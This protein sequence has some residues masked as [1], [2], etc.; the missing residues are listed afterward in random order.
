MKCDKYIGMDVH[1]ATTVVAVLDGEG[2]VILE[3]IVA[4]EA[5]AII[6]FLQSISG[7]VH[8]T[9]EESTQAEWLYEVV[10]SFVTE[11]I[12]C[13]PR[14]NQLL[15]EGSKGDKVDAHKLADL[16]RTG[17][18]RSVYHGHQTLKKLKQLVRGYETLS[19]D[20]QRV[21]VRIKAV[22]RARGIR[23]T[24]RKVYQTGQREQWLGLLDE[25]GLRERVGWLYNQ[26]DH[27]RPL[28]RQAKQ[29]MLSESRKHRA[30]ELLR[31]I[32]QFGPIRAALVAATVDTPHRF[33][34]RHQL[35]SYSG[36]AVVTRMSSEYE[37][38]EGRVVRSRKPVATRGLNRNCNRRMKEVF[39]GAAT[40]GSQTEPYRSYLQKLE[41]HGIRKEMARL[42]LARKIA[43]IALHIWKKGETFDPKKLNWTT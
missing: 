40:G 18:V 30:V 9:F 16:L 31:T 14:R 38:K 37:M 6:R 33:R 29:A 34:T 25:P 41:S 39:I 11:V 26:L 19:I 22:Y 15:G 7:P 12:V 4:T 8:V 5:G 10:R 42:T 36:L 3:T 24:G 23:T 27:L 43:A 21:M 35:W 28:R 17:M 32:P 13:D 2:K 20:T 1:Q